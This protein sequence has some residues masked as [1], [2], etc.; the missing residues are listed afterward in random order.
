M[1]IKASEGRS[2]VTPGVS[3]LGYSGLPKKG[4]FMGGGSLVLH[5][6]VL[7]MTV[8]SSWKYVY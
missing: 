2:R 5:P 1:G 3:S 7:L 8:Y 6:V 4:D